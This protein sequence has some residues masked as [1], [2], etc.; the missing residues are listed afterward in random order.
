MQL[1]IIRHADAGDRDKFAKTGKSDDQRPLSGK[2]RR[3]MRAAAKGLRAIVPACDV[4]ATSPYTRAL[5][6][7]TIVCDVYDRSDPET[8]PALEPA[9]ELEDFRTWIA[10]H[11]SAVVIMVVGHE[12]HVSSLA[13]WLSGA[14][15]DD[16][17][18][19]KGA[20]GLVEF[21]SAVTPGAGRLR[22]IKGPKELAKLQ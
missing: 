9:A 6:T 17:A 3:Q 16:I 22:W 11:S 18:F 19:K 10:G 5:Q 7:A 12:P 2:G 4:V 14:N 15:G 20:V 8:T 1:L 13:A 21:E